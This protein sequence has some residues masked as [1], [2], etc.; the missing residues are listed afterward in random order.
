MNKFHLGSLIKDEVSR[1]KRNITKFA[2]EISVTRQ[3]IY[4]I[5]SR[6]STTTDLLAR[7]SKTLN[8]NF[9]RDLA[10]QFD[11][12]NDSCC[13]VFDTT[14][15]QNSKAVAQFFCVIPNVLSDLGFDTTIVF[16][17][18]EDK[19]ILPDFGLGDFPIFF[20]IGES[21]W[22]RY[23][24]NPD[25]YLSREVY[26]S[27]D[28][29]QSIDLWGSQGCDRVFCDIKLDYKSYEEW[30]NIMTFVRDEILTILK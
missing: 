29:S 8:H 24:G 3:N 12:D 11:K 15:D 10:D 19:D 5:F 6:T 25:K 22:E 7:I 26:V 1:Q 16:V 20:T 30:L 27:A 9:F 23:N 17:P 21:L 13:D 2:D 28:G 4:D 14:P 18:H